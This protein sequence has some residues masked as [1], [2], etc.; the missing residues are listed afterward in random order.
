MKWIKR[1]VPVL[2]MVLLCA[3]FLS[4]AAGAVELK[5]GIGLV[6][7]DGLRLREKANTDCGVLAYAKKGDY[8]VIIREVGD[9]YLVDYNLQIGYMAKEYITVKERENVE[10]GYG[11]VVDKLVNLRSKPDASG[12]QLA[13]LSSGEQ[14][15]II[16]FNCGWYK[17][18]YKGLTGYIRSDLLELTQEPVEN[19][20]RSSFGQ[21]VVDTA[22]QYLGYA[23]VYGGN[24]PSKGFDCS[25]LTQYVYKQF[26]YSLNRSAAGQLDNGTSVSKDNLQLGDLVFFGDTYASSAAATHVGIYIGNGQFLHASHTGDY[27][28]ITDLDMDY[29]AVRYVGARRIQE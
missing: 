24:S 18:E 12:E 23:Y 3:V 17:V 28:K 13:Q 5:T 27:V 21:Q 9:F 6:E 20:R 1:T 7:G 4:A 10:L 2:A 15:W 14:A 22:M 19:A 16:G 11:R 26:G 8:V 29:Y 25:G